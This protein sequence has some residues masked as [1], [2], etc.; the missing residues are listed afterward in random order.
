MSDEFFKEIVDSIVNLDE[1]K[2]LEYANRAIKEKLN[3]IDVVERG[4]SAGI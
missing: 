3:L 2:A 1:E 4:F